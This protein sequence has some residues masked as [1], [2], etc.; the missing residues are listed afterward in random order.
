MRQLVRSYPGLLTLLLD[1]LAKVSG[2]GLS[3]GIFAPDAFNDTGVFG[4]G[5]QAFAKQVGG[6]GLF[7]RGLIAVGILA[8]QPLS[9]AGQLLALAVGLLR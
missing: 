6:A 3:Y 2:I 4:L 5:Q 9:R 7:L 1:S 8:L